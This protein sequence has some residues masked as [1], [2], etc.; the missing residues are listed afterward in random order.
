MNVIAMVKLSS[1]RT[2]L[3]EGKQLNIK[4]IFSSCK[5]RCGRSRYLLS[6][7]VTTGRD[8]EISARIVCVRNRNNRKD[9]IAIICTD[10]SLDE[11][12]IIRIYGHRWEKEV[13]FKD[14]QKQTSIAQGISRAVIRRTNC[15]CS[16]SFYRYMLLA[17]A[18]RD[19]EDERTLG[20]LFY[21][22]IAEVADITF[23]ES[24]QIIVNAMLST[25]QE[26]FQVTTEQIAKLYEIFMSKLPAQMQ[27]LLQIA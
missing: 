4:K 16:I 5:K 18:K 7:A 20:E 14:M 26:E 19:N 13:F 25:M 1:K 22:I 6:V 23:E 2:Y 24:M 27:Q 12:D 15:T 21:L 17:V 9:W 8:N 10:M 11:N 3:F